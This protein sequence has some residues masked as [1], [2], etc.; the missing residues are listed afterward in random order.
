MRVY[1]ING[2]AQLLFLPC[3]CVATHGIAIDIL[4][5]CLSARMSVRPSGCQTRVL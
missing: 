4:S 2:T 1:L 3:D 5:V